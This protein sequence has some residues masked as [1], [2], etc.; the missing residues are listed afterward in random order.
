MSSQSRYI[1]PLMSRVKEA[2]KLTLETLGL[3]IP[4]VQQGSAAAEKLRT[5][6]ATLNL[7]QKR[8]L[9]NTVMRGE[10]AKEKL[11]LIAMPLITSMAS[12]EYSRRQAWQSRVSFEDLVA[13]G[14]VGFMRGISNYDV[15]GQHKSATNYLGQWVIL[16]MRRGA[17][18]MDHDFFI[19]GEAVERQRKIRAIRSRLA[20]ELGRE[21]TNQEVVDAAA[22]PDYA[23]KTMMGR[24]RENKE[25]ESN[26]VKTRQRI[27][28][29][30]H[31]EEEEFLRSRSAN[32]VSTDQPVA[33][34]ES[35]T[36]TDSS[37]SS[38]VTSDTE[39]GGF[40]AN[41]TNQG[42]IDERSAQV[43]LSQLLE[44]AF[45]VMEVGS[46]Q[47][48]VI[49]R[50]FGLMP[51]LDAMTIKKV[52]EETGIPKH[53]ISRILI[54]F[55]A[56]MTRKS[57]PFHELVGRLTPEDAESMGIGWVVKSLGEFNGITTPTVSRD[58]KESGIARVTNKKAEPAPLRSEKV[59]MGNGVL[60]EFRCEYEDF[61]Y[62]IA[63]VD[64]G[65][66]P[67][68]RTCPRC[69][70]VSSRVK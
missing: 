39:R 18:S 69:K 53:R 51:Y 38:L 57:S 22:H 43:A 52:V 50:R 44:D 48:D 3:Y 21:A 67:K 25:K 13:N 65:S 37:V 40:A 24:S 9:N 7:S 62:A 49:R 8:E 58:L 70:K 15:N 63:Y 54:A 59:E 14:F 55:S 23:Q 45:V 12:K 47:C 41:H 17:D 29:L 68:S 2:E 26:R 35:Q 31:V 36:I 34:G 64:E 61:T 4:L 56:E 6:S 27:I 19:S 10:Q 66:T 46:V 28:T 33:P 5:A 60:A 20:T 32:L 42:F 30:K 16:D 11:F 1:S